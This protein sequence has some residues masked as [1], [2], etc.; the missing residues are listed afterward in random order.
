[1]P[2]FMGQGMCAG[3][4]DVSNLS[5]KLSHCLK[6]NHSEKLL[7]TY[8][9]ERYSNVKEY[10][11]TTMRMGS[12]INAVSSTKITKN[13]SSNKEGVKSMKS[14]KP[15]LGKGLGKVNDKLRGKIFPQFKLK[16]GK[17]LDEKFSSKPIVIITP[18]LKKK[19]SNKINY[20]LSNNVNG[21]SEYLNNIKSEGLIVRPDRFIIGSIKSNKISKIKNYS[22]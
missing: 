14:I 21:L 20:V 17:N 2:P 9:S 1:M 7:N 5:W 12:F 16:N 11:S 18:K 3:I 13:I 10:V 8:Q 4:R 19:I 6:N 15:K 22:I